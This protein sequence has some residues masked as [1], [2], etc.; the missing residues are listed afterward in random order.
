MLFLIGFR[1]LCL[2]FSLSQFRRLSFVFYEE[3]Q[4]QH[5]YDAKTPNVRDR[6]LKMVGPQRPNSRVQLNLGKASALK[7]LQKTTPWGQVSLSSVLLAGFCR[8]H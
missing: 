1:E 6:T 7:G 4:N 8:V 3:K 2:E 5:F